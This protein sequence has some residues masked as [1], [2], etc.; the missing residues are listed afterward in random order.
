MRRRAVLTASRCRL[1]RRP[2]PMWCRGSDVV[3]AGRLTA[4]AGR[5]GHRET[6]VDICAITTA[7][8]KAARSSV[9]TA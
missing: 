2:V 1:R 7:R 5:S 9:V 6:F 4:L 8:V 3:F